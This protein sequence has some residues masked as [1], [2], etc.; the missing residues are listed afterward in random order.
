MI[1]ESIPSGNLTL[2]EPVTTVVRCEIKDGPNNGTHI[3]VM[4][5]RPDPDEL[6]AIKNGAPIYVTFFHAMPPHTVQ[7]SLHH[8]THV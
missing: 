6:E 3:I 5:W 1:P 8:A 4:A 2:G 7:T